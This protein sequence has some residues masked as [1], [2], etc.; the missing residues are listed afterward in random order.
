MLILLSFWMFF[1]IVAVSE[2][3]PDKQCARNY[4]ELTDT[5]CYKPWT[6][7]TEAALQWSFSAR[8]TQNFDILH[9]LLQYVSTLHSTCAAESSKSDDKSDDKSND[10]RVYTSV[11]L[12]Y[13]YKPCGKVQESLYGITKRKTWRIKVPSKFAVNITF[14]VFYLD[15]PFKQDQ[16]CQGSCMHNNVTIQYYTT[17]GVLCDVDSSTHCSWKAPWS[18][19]VPS[20]QVV[21]NLT[22]GT[23]IRNCRMHYIYQTIEK[24]N[25]YNYLL[26][27]HHIKYTKFLHGIKNLGLDFTKL[28]YNWIIRGMPGYHLSLNV[29]ASFIPDNSE[30]QICDGPRPPFC[31]SLQYGTNGDFFTTM[32]YSIVKF[33]R[34]FYNNYTPVRIL[35]DSIMVT[36][37]KLSSNH[38]HLFN[39]QNG[40]IPLFH[41]V[42]EISTNS[43]IDIE[44]RITEFIGPTDGECIYGGYS[45]LPSRMEYQYLDQPHEDMLPRFYGPFCFSAPSVPLVDGGLSHLTLPNGTHTLVFYSFMDM[46]TID[47][48]VEI[49]HIQSCTGHI[50]I[51]SVC[52]NALH[53][54]VVAYDHLGTIYMTCNLDSKIKRHISIKL[55]Y[56]EERPCSTIQH[57]AGEISPCSISI[58]GENTGIFSVPSVSLRFTYIP[59]PKRKFG[60][61]N[62]STAF[63]PVRIRNR[64]QVRLNV[65][66]LD[67]SVFE[68]MSWYIRMYNNCDEA[69][70]YALTYTTSMKMK[71]INCSVHVV[72]HT[73]YVNERQVSCG[74]LIFTRPVVFTYMLNRIFPGFNI[75]ISR[76]GI[77]SFEDK[78]RVIY[79]LLQKSVE[80]IC[81]ETADYASLLYN[82]LNMNS[83]VN[84]LQF[85]VPAGDLVIQVVKSSF[86]DC[87]LTIVYELAIDSRKFYKKHIRCITMQGWID[88]QNQ[89]NIHSTVDRLYTM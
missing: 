21:L 89:V 4:H 19:I 51:C 31:K 75:N 20:S 83:T 16:S 14:L 66:Y 58:G 62:C 81:D 34:T 37:Q 43:A 13:V 78:V 15:E 2:S 11:K 59:E 73:G 29:Q 3:A 79:G 67:T 41:K 5:K 33:Y 74:H 63:P 9:M 45:I 22:S 84:A 54:I 52:F 8:Y 60:D 28:L 46:F 70:R 27:A 65:S 23:A 10:K 82:T 57:I 80:G 87:K 56:K 88:R 7:F 68:S 6:K 26:R 38:T 53:P 1:G 48:E 69:F 72:N 86:L 32:F 71:P 61:Y 42:W 39:V 77:C 25:N 36:P 50:N 76:Y 12:P 18:I 47:L 30:I 49:T 44:F 17:K 40:G 55:Q 64:Q 24:C 35:F 85:H